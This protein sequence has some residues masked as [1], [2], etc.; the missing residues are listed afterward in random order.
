VGATEQRSLEWAD[1]APL[2]VQATAT[3]TA[4][5]EAVFAVLADHERWPEWFGAVTRVVVTGAREGVGATRR[6]HLPG[7]SFEEV[8]LAWDVGS[9]WAFTVTAAR[10]KL[11]RALVEDCRL[12]PADGG[13]HIDYRMCFEPT[14]WSGP[15]MRLVA[16]RMRAQLQG[17][18]DA[19]ALRA[20]R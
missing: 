13:T 12:T 3:S 16:G 2:I 15:V 4:P 5:P 17:A 6:V 14:R 1:Q 11:M 20:A 9:R 19:L 18:V 10:P 7:A 8:F